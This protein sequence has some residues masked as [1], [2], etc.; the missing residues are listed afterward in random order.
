MAKRV[1]GACVG[2][3]LFSFAAVATVA[4]PPIAIELDTVASGLASPIRLTHAGDGSG[5]LFIADQA[6]LIRIVEN[7]VLLPTPFLDITSKL[8]T[9]GGFYDERGLLGLAFHPDYANNGRFFVRYSTPRA[10]D[11]AEVCNDPGGF[12]VG[13]HTEVLAEYSVSVGDPNIADPSSEII[14]ISVD[15][16]QFNHNSGCV[17]FGPDGY[18]YFTL[19]DG[20][21]ANDGLA[22][23]PPTHGPIG[24][25]QNIETL[26]GSM[27]RIDVDSPPDPG[28][29]YA[30][31]ADNPFVGVTGRDEIFAWGF[32]NPFSFSFDDGPGG[33]GSLYVDDVGQD[34]F[35]EVNL[36]VKGGN[37]GWVIREGLHCFDPFNTLVPPAVCSAVGPVLGDPLIDPVMEYLQPLPCTV[38]ADCAAFGVTCASN[39]LCD[40]EGGISVISGSVYR[41]SQN[42]ALVG[43]YVFGDFSNN[44]VIPGG[45]LYHFDIDGPDAFVR[46]EFCIAPDGAPLDQFVKGFG[47]DEDGE[48]YVLASDTLGPH[49]T[50][51]IV[52]RMTN[53]SSEDCNGNDLADAC[54]PDGDGDGLIDDCDGCPADPNK[55]DP[56]QCGCGTSETDSDSDGTPNC[57]DGCPNDPGKTDPGI[58][59]CGVSDILDADGD[60]VPDCVD[61][62][63]GVDD[64]DFAPECV[65]AIPT[66]SMWG[67]IV[68]AL[69]L[70]IGGK[71][72]FRDR[73]TA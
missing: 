65:G 15:E 16:P 26:L 4:A 1:I 20:G 54:E 25:G 19:G 48:I 55:T 72:A 49:G 32:R 67:L 35:E 34:L 2:G 29:T 39:G 73:Q 31:P 12:I 36:V 70:L 43:Q 41:G 50:E 11:P 14:H 61:Q 37:Y 59:G 3:L 58:C 18:L 46:R 42:P 27:I 38:D 23:V 22:D 63:P 71:I 5:R 10:G 51:G 7:G 40:N 62:C 60:G 52:Y 45:R 9:L 68:L 13:C 57:I 33:D 8:P 24:N 30:I 53:A 17:T 64:A 28:L 44:F 6:G 56:G 66:V 69:V 47:E 21:G